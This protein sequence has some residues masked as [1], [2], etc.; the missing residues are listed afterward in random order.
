MKILPQN[1]E[2]IAKVTFGQYDNSLITKSSTMKQANYLL[3]KLER[4]MN[5]QNPFSINLH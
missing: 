4:P 3:E 5:K 1:I 2:D